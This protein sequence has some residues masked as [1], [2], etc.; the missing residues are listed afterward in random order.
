MA[1][2][3]QLFGTCHLLHVPRGIFCTCHLAYLFC[4]PTRATPARAHGRRSETAREEALVTRNA[5]KMW[6]SYAIVGPK[7]TLD[8]AK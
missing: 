8:K 3:E 1:A 5:N 7:E 6:M 2:D 4:T